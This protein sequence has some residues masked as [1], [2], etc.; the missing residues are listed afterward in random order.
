MHAFKLHDRIIIPSLNTRASRCACCQAHRPGKCSIYGVC[1]E[2]SSALRELLGR[3]S[4][5]S[6]QASSSHSLGHNASDVT[7]HGPNLAFGEAPR[8]RMY[9]QL[10]GR[11]LACLL[12]IRSTN[13]PLRRG[14]RLD[15]TNCVWWS[16]R[17]AHSAC[18]YIKAWLR[19]AVGF[20]P[21]NR[22]G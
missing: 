9:L 8:D 11:R 19:A 17:D 22:R 14:T 18:E 20:K 6:F 4:F 3:P 21:T 15:C 16:P 7:S 12:R 5:A 1:G 13:N 10:R 2:A